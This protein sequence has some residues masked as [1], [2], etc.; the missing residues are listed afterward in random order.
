MATPLRK[1]IHIDMDCFYAA[2]EMRDDPSLANYPI[3]V[4]GAP[5]KR[6][7]LCTC[8]YRAREFGV[9]SAMASA[10]ALRLCPELI[11]LPVN[12]EK[13]KQA[14]QKLHE[15]F[16]QY[17]D[18]IE[19][20]SLD[21]AFLDVTA[22]T[23]YHGSATLI[24]REIRARILAQLSLTASA[25]VAPNK[26]LAKIASDWRKPDGL[27]VIT[28]DMITGF[29]QQLPIEKIHGVGKVT[30]EKIRALNIE[31]CGDLQRWPLNELVKQFG[32]FGDALYKSSRGIDERPVETDWQRKSLSVEETFSHDLQDEYS[33]AAY[34]DPLFIDLTRR[35][36]RVD[37][38]EQLQIKNI[39][40][41]IKYHD[42]SLTTIQARCSK[43]LTARMFVELF[44]RRYREKPGK[45][46]L[47]GI[48][49]QFEN[50]TNA[51]RQMSFH[52]PVSGS[53][54][55]ITQ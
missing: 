14:S 30:A 18:N 27:F 47:L 3:A 21:E 51:T 31:T 1:I 13:Y 11:I 15:I 50:A 23:Q 5:D 32:N 44:K 16:H 20:L 35:L 12:M 34:F 52:F 36:K 48:G 8:N 55:T 39:F 7:V 42:F 19:P 28:P 17:T 41:K 40:V 4:G 43:R 22:C 38:T 29:M 25:G 46:R 54:Q 10:H 49:V 2:I 26:F 45:V 24:A 37:A 6:G 9:R 53:S 33:C